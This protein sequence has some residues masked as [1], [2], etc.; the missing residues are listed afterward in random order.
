[1]SGSPSTWFPTY[2]RPAPSSTWPA[3][4]PPAPKLA[5]LASTIDR[6]S[7]ADLQQLQGWLESRGLAAYDPQQDPD[8]GKETDLSRL[9]RVHGAGFDRAFLKVM[10]ARHRTAL[11]MATTEA[12]DGTIPEVRALAQH[13]TTELQTQLQQMAA[14]LPA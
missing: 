1:M 7:H 12:R 3:T 4:S 5:R 11:G 13:M 9:S 14:L 6:Q 8:R 10:T 2:S